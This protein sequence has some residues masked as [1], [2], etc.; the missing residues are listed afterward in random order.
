MYIRVM[1]Y[2]KLL[3]LHVKKWGI[4]NFPTKYSKDMI[5]NFNFLSILLKKK[6]F[7]VYLSIIPKN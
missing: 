2:N 4:F 5:E 7:Q 6:N 1:F 3:C